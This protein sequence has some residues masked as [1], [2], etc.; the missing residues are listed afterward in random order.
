MS[1]LELLT[2][3]QANRAI[4]VNYVLAQ[5]LMAAVI[6]Y[7][8]YVFR[9]LPSSVRAAAMVGSVISILLVTFFVTGTQT[10][11]YSSVTMMSEMAGNGSELAT[12][13]MNSVGMEAGEPVSQPMWMTLL[14]V[15]QVIINLGVTIYIYMF[16]NWGEE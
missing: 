9:K 14:S 8:A 16:A 4:F 6:V 11:F 3:M 15:I 2:S 12:T 13:F 5:T 1:E 10:V 7:I